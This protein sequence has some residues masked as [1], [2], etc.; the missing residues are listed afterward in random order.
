MLPDGGT[1]PFICYVYTYG[2][3]M[4]LEEYMKAKNHIEK[5]HKKRRAA[6]DAMC[7][8]ETYDRELASMEVPKVVVANFGAVEYD[9]EAYRTMLDA[10]RPAARKAGGMEDEERADILREVRETEAAIRALQAS[11]RR[12]DECEPARG[13]PG[14]RLVESAPERA[15]DRGPDSGSAPV[16]DSPSGPLTFEEIDRLAPIRR[17]EKLMEMEVKGM[18][19]PLRYQTDMRYIEESEDYEEHRERLEMLRV[20]FAAQRVVSP[21]R[22][23]EDAD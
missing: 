20:M 4:S 2:R 10:E 12:D 11:E 6:I 1:G 8:P 9:G 23:P 17:Y 13:V 15:R 14:L 7:P 16:S 19:I 3:G 5:E 21:N 22:S 18:P